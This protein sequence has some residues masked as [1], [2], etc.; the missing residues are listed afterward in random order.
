MGERKAF[1]QVSGIRIQVDLK[2]KCI[3]FLRPGGNRKMVL[4]LP[5]GGRECPS[6]ESRKVL[7]EEFAIGLRVS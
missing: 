1:A 4:E 6:D 2:P 3:L 7:Q 5:R